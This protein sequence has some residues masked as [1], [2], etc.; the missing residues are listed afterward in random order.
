MKNG[1][2]EV[3]DGSQN[4]DIPVNEDDHCIQSDWVESQKWTPVELEAGTLLQY[5]SNL[6]IGTVPTKL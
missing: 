2:L 1:G 3:V 5:D 4:I 6:L